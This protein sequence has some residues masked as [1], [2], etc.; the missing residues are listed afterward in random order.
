MYDHSN[1]AEKHCFFFFP[2]SELREQGR[3]KGEISSHP[4]LQQTGADHTPKLTIC[5]YLDR[6][7]DAEI[8]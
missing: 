8:G 4:H 7:V 2:N 6:V 5:V 3:Q 1:R